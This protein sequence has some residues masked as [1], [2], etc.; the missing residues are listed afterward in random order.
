MRVT[1]HLNLGW[2]RLSLHPVMTEEEV[3]FIADAIKYITVNS[4]E[5]LRLYE[6]SGKTN[7]YYPL[8]KDNRLNRELT[9]WLNLELA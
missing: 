6:Y 8:Q 1:S 9:K 2:I 5:L 7:E 3:N 4:N